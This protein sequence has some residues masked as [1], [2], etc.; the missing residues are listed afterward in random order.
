MS[1]TGYILNWPYFQANADQEGCGGI[2]HGEGG[3]ITSPLGTDGKYKNG[4]RC[5]WDIETLPGYRIQINFVGRFDIEHT[6][7]C[8]NDFIKVWSCE[9]G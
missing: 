5:T 3:N 4:V 9:H 1:R 2:L 8:Q 6:D 7:D